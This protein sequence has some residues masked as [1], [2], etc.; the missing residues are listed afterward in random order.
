[1]NAFLKGEDYG[2]KLQILYLS[3]WEYL[4]TT[5]CTQV[6]SWNLPGVCKYRLIYTPTDKNYEL[7]CGAIWTMRSHK[8]STG[9]AMIMNSICEMELLS[10]CICKMINM[11]MEFVFLLIFILSI[12]NYKR[13]FKMRFANK[14]MHVYN[15]HYCTRVSY[16]QPIMFWFGL[17]I[18]VPNKE[19]CSLE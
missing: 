14:C 6:T 2:L 4:R 11:E 16:Q 12:K 9:S 8:L 10:L 5:L 15:A 1:M 18:Y 13:L 3:I 19:W 7:C 17:I